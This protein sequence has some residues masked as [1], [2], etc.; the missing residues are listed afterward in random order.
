MPA[1]FGNKNALG[2]DG[3]R[4]PMY[5]SAEEMQKKVDEYF[6]FGAN[7]KTFYTKEGDEYQVPVYT[8][9]GLAYYLGFSTRQSLLDYAEKVEFVDVIKRAKLR[10]EMAYEEGLQFPNCT[11]HIFALKNMGWNDKQE[12]D[13]TS[14][15]EKISIT[16]IEWVKSGNKD[17]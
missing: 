5:S 3:G 10:I 4:P 6:E 8:V 2:N 16:P 15:G 1:P 9:T 13:H 7:K 11:G 14:K 17:Q 12:V